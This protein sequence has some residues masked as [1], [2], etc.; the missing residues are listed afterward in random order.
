MAVQ[1]FATVT[2]Y[3]DRYGV[4]QVEEQPMLFQILCDA[5]R[6]IQALLESH[7]IDWRDPSDEY[8]DRLMQVCRDMAHRSMEQVARKEEAD[9]PEGATSYSQAA[10][11][12]SESFGWGSGTYG[13][14]YVSKSER[15]LLGLER[16]LFGVATQLP[17]RRHHAWH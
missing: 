7:A 3:E 6:K 15:Q 14:L 11:G 16:Q 17:N 9:I 5:T 2:D 8:A 13:D 12:F 1:P 10:G 4:V